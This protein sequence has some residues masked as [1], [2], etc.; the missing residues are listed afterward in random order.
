MRFDTVVVGPLTG[1]EQEAHD[2]EQ[3]GYGGIQV[4]ELTHDPFISAMLAARATSTAE[5]GTQVAI[6][7]ARNPMT[8][9]VAARD[10]AD[11]SG[12]RFSL[13]LGT[14][15]SA[16]ITRRYSMPWS[17]PAAR[18][19]DFV[20]ALRAIWRSWETGERLQ[21]RGEFYQHTLMTP[22]FSP[23]PAPFGLPPV[24]LAAVGTR[25]AAVAGRVADGVV[26]HPFTTRRYLESVLLPAVAEGREGQS[27]DFAVTGHTF[28]VTDDASALEARQRI[29]F[30][31]ST[32]AYRGVLEL[33]GWSDLADRLHA[34]SVSREPDAWT[35]MG[36]LITDE[37]LAEFAVET[38]PE[39]VFVDVA[40][41]FDGLCDRVVVPAQSPIG[42]VPR[43][44]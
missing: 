13:G 21:H 37:V 31:G 44:L 35:R 25:M 20:T 3:L 40:R 16:H 39:T 9:A 23:E 12:G 34:L 2:L 42:P 17:A 7:F 38:T 10:I 29:G 33:H 24:Q 22:M 36:D 41:R 18:M 8:V 27:R 19:E 5:V 6:A 30:Y 14:Q 43:A 15:V 1:I 4:T 11:L 32:P 26:A 28:V